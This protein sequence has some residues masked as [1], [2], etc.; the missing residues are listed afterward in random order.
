MVLTVPFE[1]FA[2]T[3]KRL[4]EGKVAFLSSVGRYTVVTAG[5]PGTG[6]LVRS[7]VLLSKEEAEKSLKR[8]GF[9]V[10]AGIWHDKGAEQNALWVAAVAYHSSEVTPGLWIETYDSEP[11]K[12]QVLTDLYDEFCQN[13]EIDDLPLDDFVRSANA[14]IVILSPENQAAMAQRLRG[15][16]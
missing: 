8:A 16:G 9:E 11:T 10:I 6:T 12:G 1:G 3:V 2:D 13:G 14:N 5:D 7:D 4:F 15:G